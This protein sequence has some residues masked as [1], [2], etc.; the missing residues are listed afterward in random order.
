MLFNGLGRLIQILSGK[1]FE[2]E[3]R[4]QGAHPTIEALAKNMDGRGRALPEFTR[5]LLQALLA[6]GIVHIQIDRPRDGG[7]P[8]FII[9]PA[10]HS[11][12]DEAWTICFIGIFFM[13]FV[14]S[15]QH[16]VATG[17]AILQTTPDWFQWAVLASIGASFGLRGFDKWQGKAPHSPSKS[18]DHS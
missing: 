2:K 6:D 16:H 10:R 13:C 18:G 11:W 9:R 3:V 1:P 17:F 4:L 15:L 14:P 5:L 8:Y 12:K 7:A